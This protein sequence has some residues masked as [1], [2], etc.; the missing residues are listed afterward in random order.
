MRQFR[1]AA[2]WGCVAWISACQ[3]FDLRA[4]AVPLA[5]GMKPDAAAAALE[6]PL[7][8]VSNRRGSA[9]YYAENAIA[10]T[11]L[12]PRDQQL[13]LQFR[14]GRLTGWKHDWGR[15]ATR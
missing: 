9:I 3:H 6:T 11:S 7:V 5:F 10:P 8:R 4:N 13:W 1:Y 12:A 14:N 2:A 15:P